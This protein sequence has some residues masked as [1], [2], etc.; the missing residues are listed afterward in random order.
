MWQ[1]RLCW[2]QQ[3][4]WRVLLLR[5]WCYHGKWDGRWRI[6]KAGEGIGVCPKHFVPWVITPVMGRFGVMVEGGCHFFFSDQGPL[7]KGG[8]DV[9]GEYPCKRVFIFSFVYLEAEV[10]LRAMRPTSSDAKLMGGGWTWSCR[11]LHFALSK[12]FRSMLRR[13]GVSIPLHFLSTL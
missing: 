9:G 10:S 1:F 8:G 12:A 6:R 2:Q 13:S 11:P 3:S 7:L 4:R 5:A